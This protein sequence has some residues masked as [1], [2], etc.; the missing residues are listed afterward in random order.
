MTEERMNEMLEHGTV[1][2]IPRLIGEIINL[3]EETAVLK[4]DFV[5]FKT[6]MLN[7]LKSRKIVVIGHGKKCSCFSCL[8]NLGLEDLVEVMESSNG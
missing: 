8:W 6:S 7:L 4:T 2:D 5:Q 1:A 3:E